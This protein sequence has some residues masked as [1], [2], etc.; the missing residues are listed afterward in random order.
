MAEKLECLGFQ[1]D[2]G[3][4]VYVEAKNEVVMLRLVSKHLRVGRSVLLSRCFY[5]Q[6]DLNY[7]SSALRILDRL[8]TLL[9]S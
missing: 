6:R 3:G 8:I 7:E 2:N 5:T 9:N 1:Y 4:V